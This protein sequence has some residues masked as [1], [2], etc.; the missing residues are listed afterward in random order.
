M[1]HFNLNKIKCKSECNYGLYELA[2]KFEGFGSGL[3]L[4]HSF[5]YILN[6]TLVNVSFQSLCKVGLEAD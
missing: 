1:V 3:L 5:A 2:V 4:G 6:F